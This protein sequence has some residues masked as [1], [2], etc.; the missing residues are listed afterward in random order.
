MLVRFEVRNFRSISDSVELSMVAVDK[1]R[2][3]AREA[4]LLG[5]RVLTRAGIYGPNAS[6][7]SNVL[8]ALVWLVDAVSDSLRLWE[9]TIPVEPFAWGA[10]PTQTTEF[11]VDY[12]VNGVRFEYVLE[13]D[14]SAV[15]REALYHYPH[16]KVRK[17]FERNGND[18]SLNK[19]LGPAPAFQELLTSTTLLLSLARRFDMPDATD[20]ARAL[21][22]VSAFGKLPGR[23]RP[24]PRRPGLSNAMTVNLFDDDEEINRL[25]EA[26]FQEERELALALL[27]LADLGVSDVVIDR[28]ELTYGGG[29][30]PPRKI[31]RARLL[32]KTPAGDAALDLH[33]ESEGTRTWFALIGPVLHALRSGS[34]IVFDEL[35]A[36]LHPVLSAELLRIFEDEALNPRGAQLIFSSHDTSLL[37]HLNRD[38]VWLT[39]KNREGA[40]TLGALADFAGERVR[41][42]VNLESAYLHGRF[43]A[44]PE[45]DPIDLRTLGLIG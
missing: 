18:I 13:V 9:D 37:N 34:P 20:F 36:S 22:E 40:T 26:E 10:G 24:G 3:A 39:Q 23:R 16:K 15:R 30:L 44:L 12:L 19:T 35:D 7:K 6:G 4:P 5:E 38:E 25:L 28:E 45:I 2:S 42:S 31:A 32:H 1:G 27:Q 41:K 14:A 8:A 43:G 33:Q 21:T 29:G 17:I 11:T